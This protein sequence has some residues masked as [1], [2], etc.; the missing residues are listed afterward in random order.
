MKTLA[1]IPY[2]VRETAAALDITDCDAMTGEDIARDL[3]NGVVIFEHYELDRLA[4]YK[5]VG[6]EYLIEH[7]PSFRRYADVRREI[8]VRLLRSGADTEYTA[9]ICGLDMDVVEEIIN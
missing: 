4:E 2:T 6:V 5:G 3:L 7:D 8:A 9:E 1:Y